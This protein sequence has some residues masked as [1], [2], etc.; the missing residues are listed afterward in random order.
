MLPL[1]GSDYVWVAKD[2]K[3]TRKQVD[4]GVRTPGFVEARSG[5]EPGELV[6]V[7]GVEMLQEGAPVQPRVVE[8]GL[9]G[10]VADTA[11]APAGAADTTGR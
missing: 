11:G 10:G 1:Q 2:G 5:I 7:G 6:V 4:L 9:V 3:A 8:R